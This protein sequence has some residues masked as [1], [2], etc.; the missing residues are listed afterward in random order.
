MKRW[1][2]LVAAVS[3]AALGLAAPVPVMPPGERTAERW[4]F[5][6]V[7]FTPPGRNFGAIA[8]QGG[9]IVPPPQPPVQGVARAAW[10]TGEEE[11]EGGSWEELATKLKIEG[12]K[13]DSAAV[14][15]MRVLNHLGNKGWEMVSAAQ[16]TT[17]LGSTVTTFVFKRRAK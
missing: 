15:K 9:N 16:P 6:E 7:T 1:A 12:A 3:A 14:Y 10:V 5:C 2:I 11:I 8:I 17:P 4:E 13:T